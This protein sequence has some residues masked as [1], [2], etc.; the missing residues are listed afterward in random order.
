MFTRGLLLETLP[1]EFALSLDGAT[2]YGN[3]GDIAS[4]ERD[5]SFSSV[6]Y[7]NTTASGGAIISRRNGAGAFKG[8]E[9]N[10]TS[11][12]VGLN[13]SSNNVT[14]NRLVARTTAATFNDGFWHH[15]VVTYDGSS[16]TS[17][18]KIYI[19]GV[20]EAVTSV[21]NN[22]TSSIIVS[23][24]ANIG[25]RNNGENLFN[26]LVDEVG[27]YDKELSASEVT[28][29]YNNKFV[30]RLLQLPNFANLYGWWRFTGIDKNNL[31]AV[32][33]HSLNV[34]DMTG[35]NLVAGDFSTN[36]F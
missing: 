12:Q 33:D 9:V 15:G 2:K 28:Q 3:M 20:S 21:I 32:L 19:D 13:L 17:G 7:F 26:G 25:S 34:R 27:I 10:T 36:V 8:W 14:G 35:V 29:I 6:F 31:P 22:L 30:Q 5:F 18:V 24:D 16:S 4:F 11:G 1:N 23:A